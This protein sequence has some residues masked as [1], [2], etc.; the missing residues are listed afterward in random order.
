MANTQSFRNTIFQLLIH[1]W[2]WRVTGFGSSIVGFTCY[3]LSPSFQ[4]LFGHWSTLKIVIYS[5]VCS[6]FSIMMLFVHRFRGQRE[7]SI[8]LKTHV[9]YVV[10]TLTSVWSFLEDRSEEGKV[11]KG[12]GKM[13]DAI[14]CGAFSW[15][16]LS[17]SRQLRVG[18]EVGVS[19]FFAG[20]FLVTVMKMSLK[21]GLLAAL[22]CYLLINVRSISDFLLQLHAR[23]TTQHGDGNSTQSVHQ[24]PVV[25]NFVDLE[26]NADVLARDTLGERASVTE[27]NEWTAQSYN[28]SE[29]MDEEGGGENLHAGSSLEDAGTMTSSTDESSIRLLEQEREWTEADDE[30]GVYITIKQLADGTKE[31]R[32]IR[33]SRR[34]F[35]EAA[36]EICLPRNTISEGLMA[37]SNHARPEFAFVVTPF[38]PEG[39]NDIGRTTSGNGA[40]ASSMVR[41]GG[42]ETTLEPTV[43]DLLSCDT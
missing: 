27:N 26:A 4:Y 31:L 34:R 23:H 2:L 21:L 12:H 29:A 40:S 36:A 37:L 30:P 19:N 32:R 22:F 41:L 20:C 11:E 17:L 13:M 39:S 14:S 24:N 10:L 35:E 42:S 16:A 18:F 6:L 8:L 43:K 25:A 15:M 5:M 3:A 7:R 9:G 38:Q 33:F 1:P 28:P